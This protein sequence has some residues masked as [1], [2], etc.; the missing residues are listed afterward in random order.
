MN[1]SSEAIKKLNSLKICILNSDYSKSTKDQLPQEEENI[2]YEIM[3]KFLSG[4]N[5]INDAFSFSIYKNQGIC[6]LEIVGSIDTDGYAW[7]VSTMY[8]GE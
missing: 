2:T 4:S 8:K 7:G 5:Q 1:L 6:S 3:I